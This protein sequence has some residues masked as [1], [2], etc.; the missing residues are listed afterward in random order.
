MDIRKGC[1][2]A[3]L[4]FIVA[5]VLDYNY[6]EIALWTDFLLGYVD[7]T[8]ITRYAPIIISF[9]ALIVSMFSLR[10]SRKRTEIALKQLNEQQA[11]RAEQ[12]LRITAI[13]S[14]RESRGER[15]GQWA[16]KF[17][18]N[19]Q[20]S[21]PVYFSALHIDLIFRGEWPDNPIKALVLGREVRKCYFTLHFFHAIKST[22]GYSSEWK[23]GTSNR[24]ALFNWSTREPIYISPESERLGPL[25]GNKELWMLI[26]SFPYELQQDLDI[27]F[28]LSTI[29]CQFD[30]DQERV[31]VEANIDFGSNLINSKLKREIEMLLE[32][33]S[34]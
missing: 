16:V 5:V 23:L 27:E 19:N 14:L 24:A 7:S 29:E 34:P 18:V 2:L 31:E 28:N 21:E 25:P 20:G 33:Y 10:T 12:R 4:V 3:I 17:V 22:K 1:L 15:S 26:G 9:I 8:F 11:A 13:E 30:T 6:D 32:K